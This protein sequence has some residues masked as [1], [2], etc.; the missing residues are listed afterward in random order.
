MI[1][2]G[3]EEVLKEAGWSRFTSRHRRLAQLLQALA[4]I[5]FIIAVSSFLLHLHWKKHI[6][7]RNS[8]PISF[9]QADHP[10][11]Q[12]APRH[13]NQSFRE[14]IS[15]NNAVNSS[16][17]KKSQ[18]FFRA[19]T[20][21]AAQGGVVLQWSDA[22]V[23]LLRGARTGEVFFLFYEPSLL[24][25]TL[26]DEKSLSPQTDPLEVFKKLAEED[27]EEQSIHQLP[28]VAV[29]KY[30]MHRLSFFLPEHAERSLPLA[31]V[32]RLDSGWTKFQA[33]AQ[34]PYSFEAMR[35]FLSS[36]RKG[37]VAPLLRTEPLPLS[38]EPAE[39]IK[40]IV[41]S[42]FSRMVLEQTKYD[43]LVI[44]YANWCG[45]CRRFQ[46]GMQRLAERFEKISSIAFFKMEVSRNDVPVP[47][48]RVERVP[49]VVFFARDSERKS[50][51]GNEP[52][53][54]AADAVAAARA[55]SAAAWASGDV[56]GSSWWVGRGVQRKR[57]F[58]FSHAEPD[59]LTYG[60]AFLMQ[61]AACKSI[62]LEQG[63]D[64]NS[65]DGKDD[66]EL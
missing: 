46:F 47:G 66:T 38:P 48:L 6:P 20:A 15:S 42:T 59:V 34:A 53:L 63:K 22:T 3:K 36:Y 50:L 28:F 43:A 52:Q 65:I 56:L 26:S 4:L 25:A 12:H 31:M 9:L 41:A 57:I 24:P 21:A 33:P 30:E 40:T 8:S 61:H 17:E 32:V 7:S 45:H 27:R 18:R 11:N 39:L 62:D 54:S 37:E 58:T 49:H 2:S 13:S 10:S 5:L 55:S 44:L 51:N 16:S 23:R 14:N 29:P 1:K 19:A 35:T 64:C 60:E